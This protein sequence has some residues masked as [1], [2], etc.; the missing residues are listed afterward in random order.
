[1]ERARGPIGPLEH[2]LASALALRNGEQSGASWMPPPELREL[3]PLHTNAHVH[4]TCNA[5]LAKASKNSR[6]IVP[7][8]ARG[9]KLKTPLTGGCPST[10]RIR[11]YLTRAYLKLLRKAA[12]LSK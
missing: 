8:A 3:I 4:F 12:S 2:G 5:A 1:V 11:P 7:E 6:K 9:C 10:P